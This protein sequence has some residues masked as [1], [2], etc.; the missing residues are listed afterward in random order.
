MAKH[1]DSIEEGP[2]QH[3]KDTSPCL[4][5]A[6]GCL[7]SGYPEGGVLQIGAQLPRGQTLVEGLAQPLG[8]YIDQ[9]SQESDTTGQGYIP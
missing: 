2:G 6:C 9:G 3:W 4:A 5:L 1:M 7:P 8:A